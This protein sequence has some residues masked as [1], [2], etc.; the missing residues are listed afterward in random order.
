VSRPT[1]LVAV[2]LDRTADDVVATALAHARALGARLVLAHVV[3]EAAAAFPEGRIAT[4]ANPA[5]IPQTPQLVEDARRQLEPIAER[6][7]AAGVEAESVVTHGPPAATVLDLADAWGATVIAIG[8]HGRRGVA[9]VLVGS[10][11]EA[12]LRRAKVP[13]L[14]VPVR[15]HGP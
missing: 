14:V 8:T 12:V 3:P 15:D 10:V 2:D 1:V 7:R 4:A 9:R 6:C 13:L 11:A 5:G